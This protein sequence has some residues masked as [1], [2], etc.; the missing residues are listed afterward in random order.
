[1][2]GEFARRP[3]VLTLAV[4]LGAAACTA[5]GVRINN[6]DISQNYRTRELAF[7]A[8]DRDLRVVVI[9]NPF[10]ELSQE[11]FSQSVV[12][13]MQGR[14]LGYSAATFSLD[15]PIEYRP[16]RRIRVLMVF[17]PQPG[18]RLVGLCRRETNEPEA[19]RQQGPRA[20]RIRVLGAYCQGEQTTTR[21]I[22]DVPRGADF[23]S[24]NMDGLV[25]QMTANLFPIRND[26][27]DRDC[28]P[29]MIAC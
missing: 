11:A 2:R 3:I 1:M 14:A 6:V 23:A 4:L 22:G 10:P 20:D 26:D 12:D 8:D 18:L 5:E 13:S 7:F 24:T 19:V 29:F 27:L 16:E 28:S 17:D 25:S 9:N 21:A 15:P